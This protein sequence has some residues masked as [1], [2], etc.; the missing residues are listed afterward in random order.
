MPPNCE[1]PCSYMDFGSLKPA[2]VAAV[3]TCTLVPAIW[4]Y[5]SILCESGIAIANWLQCPFTNW[6]PE[7]WFR[8]GTGVGIFYLRHRVEMVFGAHPFPPATV[9]KR[10]SREWN[11]EQFWP[12]VSIRS[13]H[14]DGYS[15]THTFR[16]NTRPLPACSVRRHKNKYSYVL[17]STLN[18]SYWKFKAKYRN[19]DNDQFDAQIFKIHLLWSSTCTCFE[20]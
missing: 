18:I 2:M 10:C 19:L 9:R 13:G 11:D 14:T 6:S 15:V 4:Q 20:Q 1:A 17:I 8:T 5:S 3:T 7:G 16:S 12:L